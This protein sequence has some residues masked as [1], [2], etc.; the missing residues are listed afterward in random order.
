MREDRRKYFLFEVSPMIMLAIPWSI[1]LVLY[2][3]AATRNIERLPWSVMLLFSVTLMFLVFINKLYCIRKEKIFFRS[4]SFK[5]LDKYIFRVGMIWFLGTIFEIMHA[6]GLPVIWSI[7][8]SS[9]NYTDF[10][11]GSLHGLL[12]ALYFFLVASV[13]LK[14]FHRKS[15]K[16]LLLLLLVLMWPILMLGRGI[17]LTAVLQVLTIYLFTNGLTL[18]VLFRTLIIVLMVVV[19]FGFI[20]DIRGPYKNPFLYLTTD[21]S[22][23]VFEVL[24]SGFLWVYMYLTSPLSNYGYNATYYEPAWELNYSL[25]NI[26]P[27]AF[28]S[29]LGASHNF[30]FIDNSLN[31]STM[32]A[33]SHSDF[34]FLG[35]VVLIVLL[36]SWSFFWFGKL[37]KSMYYILPYSMVCSV[38]IMSVFYN[39]FLLLPYLIST[40]LQGYIASR[41]F[42]YDYKISRRSRHVVMKQ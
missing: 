19:I 5:N 4:V 22:R 28:R 8:G 30:E 34:G 10:G 16:R 2:S 37:K 3:L 40:L 39:L 9:K 23:I 1:T 27:S 20:G 15:K 7:L 21:T 38:L 31:V 41:C 26:V 29:D 32:F 36:L 13:S 17:F 33:S 11:I 24:P 12:N 6:R 42:S 14:Y 18:K 25:V 35:D